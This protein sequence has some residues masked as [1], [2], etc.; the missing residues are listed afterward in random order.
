M[1]FF[2]AMPQCSY[3][4]WF[5]AGFEYTGCLTFALIS[6]F[7]FGSCWGSFMNVCIWRMPRRESVV[8]A[9]S[10]CTSC[11]ADIHWYDNLPVISYI[12]LRGR[13]RACHTPYSC[14]YFIIEIIMGLLFCA[15]FIK[16]GLTQQVPGVIASYW[17]LL[18]F[19]V[20]GAWIDAKHR[21]IPD[22]LNYPAMLLGVV[23]AGLLPEVWGTKTW[24]IA[25]IYSLISG[26]VPGIF[27]A[28]FAYLGEK[29]TGKEVLGW[30]DVKFI[31]ACGTL[32]GLPGAFFI[33]LAGS[34][35]GSI[36]GTLWMLCR[37]KK[38]AGSTIAFGPFLAG[39]AILWV[40]A[41]NW[42]YPLLKML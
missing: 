15:V 22:A 42:F 1:L 33:L 27:L 16:A 10:H 36:G 26:A 25:I 18:L 37:R 7:I 4:W 31:T 23:C 38:L 2:Q 19:A 30:G 39:S 34:L 6:I 9:P 29:I 40:F 35:A 41:G 5:R 21:I 28:L 11:G 24:Y 20:A 8:T 3:D 12:V 14:R 32:L 13:C 17:I